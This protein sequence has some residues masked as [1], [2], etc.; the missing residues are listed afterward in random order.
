MAIFNATPIVFDAM[1]KSY[2]YNDAKVMVA[3][4]AKSVTIPDGVSAVIFS[5]DTTA[6]PNL[7]VNFNHATAAVIPVAD[8]TTGVSPS[9]NPGHCKGLTPGK[10]ISL[11][12]ATAGVVVLHWLG[13]PNS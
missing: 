11:I 1:P 10:S 3:N 5:R 13:K 4:T 2:L 7:Y 9:L 12:S 6:I 8:S